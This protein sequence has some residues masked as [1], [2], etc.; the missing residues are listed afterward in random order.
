MNR[1]FYTHIQNIT[2]K[3]NHTIYE[4]FTKCTIKDYEYNASYNPTLLSG[5]QG[6]L[7]Q[8][9]S[10]NNS[11]IVYVTPSDNY[12]ILKDFTTGSISGSEFSPYVTTVGL[13]NDAQDLLATAKMAS[14]IPIS[15]NT[16][17]TFLVKWDTNFISNNPDPLVFDYDIVNICG[18]KW[19]TNELDVVT[20]RNGDPI[21]Q[22]TD[23]ATWTSLTTGAWCW[24]NNDP[25]NAAYG[26]LYNWYA[27]NDSRGLAPYGYRIATDTDWANLALCLDPSSNTSAYGGNV[28]EIV[29]GKL[30]T[31]GL[32]YWNSPNTDAVNSIGF[33]AKGSGIR[34]KL[35]GAFDLIGDNNYIWTSTQDVSASNKGYHYIM[36]YN[37]ASLARV[38]AEKM[39]GMT[40]RFIKES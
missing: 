30:K 9:S 36:Y 2:F 16:D 26:R 6:L 7:T 1:V 22:V 12:G 14:P 37:G 40:V 8:Y 31:T 29:G 23:G 27:V 28:S 21:P 38:S 11:D 13:Y 3:N 19:V 39:L 18:T 17:M 20:Y 25:V 32:T 35:A 34:K 4:N 15:A 24:Y 5:S 10:S 33:N